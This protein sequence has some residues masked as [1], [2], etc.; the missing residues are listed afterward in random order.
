MVRDI[1]ANDFKDITE[2][3]CSKKPLIKATDEAEGSNKE[4]SKLLENKSH[5]IRTYMT[6]II[7]MTDLTLTT[8]LT[9]EQR[10]YLTIVKSSTKLLLKVLNDILNYSK[11]QAEKDDLEQIPYDLRKTIYEV[12]D[13]FHVAA[14]QKDIYIRL[15]TL[16]KTIPKNIIG[17]PI[18]LKQVLSNLVG[19]SVRFTNHGEVNIKV[20]LVELDGSRVQLKFMVSDT[21]IGISEDKFVKLFKRS[22]Q[23]NDSNIK[24]FGGAGLTITKKLVE[25]MNGDI[26][27]DSKEGVGSKFCFTAVF[28]VQGEEGGSLSSKQPS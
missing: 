17:N 28:G 14:K 2:H 12:I 27:V 26:Y 6:R 19:N 4:K 5:E 8:E 13:L 1:G 21:G 20:D 7:S 10:D 11:I 15:D 24:E 18:R 22:S 16:D 23:V 3:I 25:S 9:E